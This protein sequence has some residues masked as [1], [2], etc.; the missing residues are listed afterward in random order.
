MKKRHYLFIVVFYLLFQMSSF[1]VFA[2]PA[3]PTYEEQVKAVS[4]K[5][6]GTYPIT[7]YYDHEGER[8]KKTSYLTVTGDATVI[9]ESGIAIDAHPMSVT[10][11]EARQYT[12]EDW[13]EKSAAKAWDVKDGSLK[14]IVE[15]DVS[16]IKD[17]AGE[18]SISFKTVQ[19]IQIS[20]VVEVV[21]NAPIEYVSK[22]KTKDF[23][24]ELLDWKEVGWFNKIIFTAFLVGILLIPLLALFIQ[25]V[26]TQNIVKKIFSALQNRQEPEK[27]QKVTKGDEKKFE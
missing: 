26:S 10:V 15:V 11:D 17:L 21:N 3:F 24:P 20:V 16:K 8:L 5:G 22:Q 12:A 25:Y 13:V 1:P 2:E 14:E 27:T 18:Y 9:D 23:T 19:N 4:E 6:P 7:F